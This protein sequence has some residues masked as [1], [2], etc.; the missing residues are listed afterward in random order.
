MAG[1]PRVSEADPDFK[2]SV[3]NALRRFMNGDNPQRRTYTGEALADLLRI[4]GASLSRYLN[5]GQ[6]M[7]GELLA[8]ALLLGVVL[9]YRA[10]EIRASA[11][12]QSIQFQFG[13]GAVLDPVTTEGI[14][15]NVPRRSPQRE[16]GTVRI[17]V[18]G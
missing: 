5:Q 17:S 2:E 8:R 13:D 3:A 4:N 1:R 7:G 10:M 15:V 12:G 14:A 6:V 18:V 9:N 16:R 11:P